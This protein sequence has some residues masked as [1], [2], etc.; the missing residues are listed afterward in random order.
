MFKIP[1]NH[2]PEI[3]DKKYFPVLDGLRAV[4]ILFVVIGHIII[5]TPAN[6]YINGAIGV[7]IFFV[8]SGFLITTLLL[9]ERVSNGQISLRNFYIRR[10]L[11][12]LPVAYLYLLVIGVLNY[13]FNLQISAIA[14]LSDVFYF[15]NTPINY[16]HNAWLTDHFWTLSIEEQFYLLFPLLMVKNFGR[17]FKLIVVLIIGIP[18]LQF[19]SYH[20]VG[21]LYSNYWVHKAAMAIIILFGH[22]TLSILIGSLLALLIFNGT[23]KPVKLKNAHWLST[24]VFIAAIIF[25]AQYPVLMANVSLSEIIFSILIAVVIFLCLSFNDLLGQLLSTPVLVK[26]GV[27]S[28][29]IYI[30]QQLFTYSQPWQHAF[31]YA[32][33]WWFNMPLLLIVSIASYYLYERKFLKL[34]DKFKAV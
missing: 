31:K 7:E 8:L 30:W 34:K 28:Y 16:G 27:L 17:Y 15:R 10:T 5:Y 25:N 20:N 3:V 13:I 6:K 22:G 19:L 33:A 4:A 23:L 32:D 18:L 24:L 1:G 2:I 12:I 9:K 21:V 11:R 29:S 14:F 26:V